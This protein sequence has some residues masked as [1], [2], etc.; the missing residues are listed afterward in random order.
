[1]TDRLESGHAPLD[2]VLGGGLPAHAISLITGLP[3]TGKTI[4]AQQYMFQNARSDRP[5]I[6]FS[7]VSEPLEKM[8]RFGQSL[9]FFDRAEVGRS[10]FYEDLGQE[11]NQHGLSGVL[12]QIGALLKE[13]RPGIMVIDSFKALHAYAASEGE[14]R[15]FLHELAARLT[16][17]PVASL[18]VGEYEDSAIGSLAEFAVADAILDLRTAQTGQR[19]TRFVRV[20]KL[21]GSGFRA[22]AHAYRLGPGGVHVFPRLAD[23]RV[24]SEY[25][26]RHVRLSSGIAALDEMVGDGYWP[27]ATTLVAGPSGSGKTIMGLHFIFAGAQQG[28]PGVIAS[29]QENPTQLQRLAAGLEWSLHEPDVELM[30]RSPVDIYLDEWVYDLLKA[31]ERTGARRVLVDSL[32]DL[33]IAAPDETRFREFMYSLSQ[34]F[35]LQGVSMLMTLEIADIYGAERLSDFGVSHLSDNVVMLS[36][37]EDQSMLKR[38]ATVIKTRASGHD[39]SVRQFEIGPRGI[40]LGGPAPPREGWAASFGG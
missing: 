11:V 35:S 27:G 24:Q 1:M 5:G 3:G 7:T 18:W 23:L 26:L 19:E 20:R 37:Y 10:V 13:R 38:S 8:L 29:L 32:S 9:D 31:V 34:R 33:K 2:E 17:F 28:E 30:Y 4:L 14:F 36:R 40:K 12:D 15:Q 21:R 25:P 22:G 39:P 16:A 6:Y